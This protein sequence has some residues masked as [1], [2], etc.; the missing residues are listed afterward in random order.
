MNL[1][2]ISVKPGHYYV[3]LDVESRTTWRSMGSHIWDIPVANNMRAISE[4]VAD[5][6]PAA[7]CGYRPRRGTM[8]LNTRAWGNRCPDCRTA[9]RNRGIMGFTYSQAQTMMR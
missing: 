2:Q 6:P 9:E 3:W 8:N 7:L 1:H 5:R 4:W